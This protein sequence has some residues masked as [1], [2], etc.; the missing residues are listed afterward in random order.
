MIE[1]G[2]GR[3]SGLTDWHLMDVLSMWACLQDQETQGHWKHVAGWRKVCDLAQTHLRRLQQYRS[4]LAE[5]WPPATNA[6]A[7]TYLGELDELIGKVQRTHDTAAANHD[8][9]AA[10]ARA[11]DSARPE[12]K[13]LHDDYARKLHQKRGYEA[14]LADPR[15]AAGSRVVDPPVTDADLEKLNTQARG[16]MFGL[17]G[18]LQQAQAM[19]QK[20]PP[21]RFPRDVGSTD[22]YDTPGSMPAIP[23][24]TPIPIT[25][26]EP[27]TPGLNG[28]NASI[29]SPAMP[30]S[31]V[32]PT[33]GGVV[34]T[35]PPILNPDT[36]PGAHLGT[37][38]P[39][40]TPTIPPT[41]STRGQIGSITGN[42]LPKSQG[43]LSSP[44]PTM[45]NDTPPHA[46]KPPQATPSSGIIG[47]THGIASGQPVGNSAP[48]RVNPIGGLIGGGGAGLA[49][50]GGAGSRPRG[51]RGSQP[52][53]LPP[54]TGGAGIGGPPSSP[55]SNTRG[56]ISSRKWNADLPWATD[57]GVPPVVF[58]PEEDGPIDPG[59]AIGFN[60]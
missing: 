21:A 50:S 45:H 54:I 36:N 3:T 47:G 14:T 32:G 30:S 20:P 9:L 33:L 15:A 46:I 60:R 7:R 27:K 58:P 52:G 24:V 5:A 6:A 23:P 19:L 56:G 41:L 57:K 13:R 40:Q 55:P 11:I 4:G 42:R 48:R 38:G 53:G 18:E 26:P 35:G 31:K 22:A 59:P 44:S 1:R 25:L 12:I 43:S 28:A 10:A 29:P 39:Q 17:S 2:G 34:N 16:V 49:P 37:A 51:G 8:A